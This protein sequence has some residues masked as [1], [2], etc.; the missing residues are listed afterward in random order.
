MGSS[1]K[2]HSNEVGRG[3]LQRARMMDLSL[4]M[5]RDTRSPSL[6][7]NAASWSG[8]KA[9]DL[10]PSGAGFADP[11]GREGGVCA[12]LPV[13]HTYIYALLRDARLELCAG[14]HTCPVQGAHALARTHVPFP[15]PGLADT[16]AQHNHNRPSE[17]LRRN[18]SDSIH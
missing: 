16:V 7:T 5:G 4:W 17:S 14:R 8:E 2:V 13:H 10:T 11:E 1:A 18:A 15:L 3:S 12:D 9:G 6:Q